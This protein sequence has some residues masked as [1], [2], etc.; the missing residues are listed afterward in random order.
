M[1]NNKSTKKSET[2]LV[3]GAGFGAAF[4]AASG[5]I[6]ESISI[7]LGVS[8]GTALG[9]AIALVFGKKI[10]QLFDN[11]DKTDSNE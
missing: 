4:G 6:F 2:I 10:I 3:Y 1:A 8:I 11:Q 7:A 9:V 5:A